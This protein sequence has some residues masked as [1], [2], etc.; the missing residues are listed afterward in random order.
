MI[1]PVFQH[2]RIRQHGFTLI[3]LLVVI[4]I[5]GVLISLLLPA[6]QSAREAARRTQCLNNM[7]QMNL[8]LQNY[9]SAWECFPSGV[10]NPSGPISNKP[11]GYHFSWISQLL[12]NLEQGMTFKHI[13]FDQGVYGPANTTV[14]QVKIKTMLC[15]SDSNSGSAMSGLGQSSYVGNHHHTEAPI[16]VTNTGVFFLNSSVRTEDISDGAS[17]T[18]AFGEKVIGSGD[19]GWAS[20]TNSTLRNGGTKITNGMV[21]PPLATPTNPDPV[22]GFSSSHP[23]GANFAWADGH[24]SFVRGSLPLNLL[25]NYMNRQDG[26]L[27]FDPQ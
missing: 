16:D 10:V 15:P 24:V 12:P 1:S 5:I 3:E 25:Q 23:G 22:G 21:L 7:M 27:I 11:E 14:R 17:N 13:N 18:I 19:L 20:G 26:E 2:P 4:S 9:E 8:A 6:V